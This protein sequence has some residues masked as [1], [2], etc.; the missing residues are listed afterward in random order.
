MVYCRPASQFCCGCSIDFGVKAILFFNL[1]RNCAVLAIATIH[2][3][4]KDHYFSSSYS[5]GQQV[6][7]AGF[8]LFGLPLI[9]GGIWGVRNKVGAPL[10]LYWY[11]MIFTFLFDTGF[12][13]WSVV[14]V[15][16]CSSLPGMLSGNGQAF[17]CGAARVMSSATLLSVTVI[18]LY[19]LFIVWS[20][21]EDIARGGHGPDLSD[22]KYT[23][24]EPTFKMED[25]YAFIEGFGLDQSGGAK[26]FSGMGESTPLFGNRAHEMRYPPPRMPPSY[27]VS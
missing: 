24:Q 19:L 21:C 1:F 25:H 10:Y 12:V 18:Q 16:P 6:T 14:L 3:V 22:L 26:N 2:V 15:G 20:H 9:I 5:L 7:L 8:A 23:S 27:R 13:F 11:Y 4:F 17:M